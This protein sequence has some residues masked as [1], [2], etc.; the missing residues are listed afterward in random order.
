ME[1]RLPCHSGSTVEGKAI[2]VQWLRAQSVESDSLG[3]NPSWLGDKE[4]LI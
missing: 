3:S 1:T 4:L 2:L